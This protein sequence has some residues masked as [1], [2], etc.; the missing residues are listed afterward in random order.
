MALRPSRKPNASRSCNVAVWRPEP[1]GCP[2]NG[3][4]TWISRFV[5]E[6]RL[7]ATLRAATSFGIHTLASC[8][9]LEQNLVLCAILSYHKSCWRTV[10]ALHEVQSP[11]GPQAVQLA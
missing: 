7:E 8:C 3:R 5:A 9:L 4:H 6:N 2:T 11:S 10:L 1:A